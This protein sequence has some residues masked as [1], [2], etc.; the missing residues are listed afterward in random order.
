MV[1]DDGSS[2]EGF[3]CWRTTP[4]LGGNRKM[5]EVEGGHRNDGKTKQRPGGTYRNIE[6]KW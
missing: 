2:R 4:E 3:F 5:K 6:I 1:G